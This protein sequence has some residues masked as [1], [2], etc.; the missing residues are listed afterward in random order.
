M[1]RTMKDGDAEKDLL[2]GDDADD[3]RPAWSAPILVEE[4]VADATQSFVSSGID[5]YEA[6]NPV[7]YGS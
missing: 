5:N 3:P 4:L 2:K 1:L 6:S 7:S